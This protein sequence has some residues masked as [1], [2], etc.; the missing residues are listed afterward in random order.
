MNGAL[1]WCRWIHKMTSDRAVCRNWA[2]LETR[3]WLTITI[4]IFSLP[5]LWSIFF[6]LCMCFLFWSKN[7]LSFDS[8]LY[9]YLQFKL[10]GFER[11]AGYVCCQETCFCEKGRRMLLCCVC[12]HVYVE[13]ISHAGINTCEKTF[14]ALNSFPPGTYILKKQLTYT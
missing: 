13:R 11:H 7:N 4:L 6:I 12:V 8:D 2:P 14:P 1:I 3:L 9:E 5:S 10:L